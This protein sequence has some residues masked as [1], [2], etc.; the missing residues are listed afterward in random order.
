MSTSRN[1]LASSFGDLLTLHDLTDQMLPSNAFRE[2]LLLPLI[3]SLRFPFNCTSNRQTIEPESS[4]LQML[5]SSPFWESL[6]SP[7]I[8]CLIPRQFR[9]C[10]RSLES[11]R[12]RSAHLHQ[13]FIIGVST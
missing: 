5:F 1:C 4:G 9:F 11:E 13:I 3:A 12:E 7:L 10:H 8:P 6:L 2:R